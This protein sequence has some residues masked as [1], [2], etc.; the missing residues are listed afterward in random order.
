MIATLLT[1]NNKHICSNCRMEQKDL[2][3]FCWFC[4]SF[5]SNY[6]EVALQYYKDKNTILEN[7]T[8]ENN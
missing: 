4:D 7:Y 2:R 6:E 5:F 3:A 1:K 8:E